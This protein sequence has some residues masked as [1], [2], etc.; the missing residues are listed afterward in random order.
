MAGMLIVIYSYIHGIRVILLGKVKDVLLFQQRKRV[1]V[2]V[3][4]L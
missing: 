3:F 1:L 2:K 4:N